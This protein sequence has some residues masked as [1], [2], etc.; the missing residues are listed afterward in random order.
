MAVFKINPET[1]Y[2]PFSAQVGTDS[3]YSGGMI[4]IE[5]PFQPGE[6]V[7]DFGVADSIVLSHF[8]T[9]AEATILDYELEETV[10]ATEADNL[11]RIGSFLDTLLEH[12]NHATSE[13]QFTEYWA[14]FE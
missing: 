8:A 10:K 1:K 7:T 12:L 2:G 11:L 4:R 6:T 3:G 5:P 13:E 9:T 14:K